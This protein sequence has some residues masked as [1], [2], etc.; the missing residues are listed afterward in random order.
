MTT[1][2]IETQPLTNAQAQTLE[3]QIGCLVAEL[4]GPPMRVQ[5]LSTK[6][7]SHAQAVAQAKDLAGQHPDRTYGVLR[8]SATYHGVAAR[9]A[10]QQQE[11]SQ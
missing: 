3:E 2:T 6:P 11:S 4:F 10:A 8:P 5:V 9:P 7:V 1:P